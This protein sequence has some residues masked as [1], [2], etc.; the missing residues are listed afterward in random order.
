[1]LSFL[2]SCV[3]DNNVVEDLPNLEERQ[4]AG[5]GT[6]VFLASSN[7]F[8]RP[9]PNLSSLELDKHLNGDV[10]F[11][12][13]FVTAPAS[14]NSGLGTVYNNNSC[15]S[16][17]PRDGR[18]AFP[19]DVNSF[20]GFFLRTS[21]PGNSP[22]GSPVPTPGFGAQLQNH[23]IFGF[24]PEVKFNVTFDDK[25]DTLDGAEVI[26]RSP[27]YA[28]YDAYKP[29][30]SNA[31]LSPRLAPP[32][33]GSGLLEAI[34][35]ESILINEDANDANSDGISGRAN[36]VFDKI[37]GQ[38]QLGR[39]GWKASTATVYEQCAGAYNH[40]M[41]ITNPLISVETWYGQQGM[42]DGL[43]DDPELNIET[44]EAVAHYC[45]TLGVPASR[46][47][48]NID[49]RRGAAI[50]EKID[51]AKCHIPK[52]ET[53]YNAIQALSYQTIYPYSDMLLHDMGDALADNRPDYLAT[54]NEWKTRPLWGIGLTQ[55]VNGHTHFLHDGRAKNM[56]EAILWHGGEAENSKQ[57]FKQLSTKE[58]NDLLLFLNSL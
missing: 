3:D 39:F 21:I 6:T 31:L 42:D 11:N 17:H 46:D 12:A 48:A 4:T 53:G 35:S 29:F 55:V 15:V 9:S 37:S 18:A 56:T 34:P 16:C 8:G 26:L 32:V 58:R 57:K 27:H 19:D 43:Q 24:V 45:K 23:A 30:P 14:V 13:I 22:D 50:F 20:S 5:G 47:Y 10:A 41:G 7:S 28:V 51:C 1:M 38:T 40:D 54:G 25:K 49:V 33:F 52:M 44:L 36:F 2:A